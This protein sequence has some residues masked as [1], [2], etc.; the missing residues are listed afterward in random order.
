SAA[1]PFASAAHPLALATRPKD[2]EPAGPGNV[3]R[4]LVGA[5]GFVR[6]SA[7]ELA[8]AFGVSAANVT[9]A[10][11]SGALSISDGE[12]AVAY[13][14]DGDGIVFFSGAPD[15]VLSDVRHFFVRL[16]GGAASPGSLDATPGLSA[17][18]DTYSREIHLEQEEFAGTVV[19][20]DARSDFWFWHVISSASP[21]MTAFELDAPAVDAVRV[22][23][24]MHAIPDYDAT[25]SLW[26]DGVMVG[27][28]L[29]E[30]G[31]TRLGFDVAA[32][33]LGTGEH[34]LEV[35]AGSG[36]AYVD[37]IDLRVPTQFT[38]D[39]ALFSVVAD[40]VLTLPEADG[41]RV[42]DVT[43][44]RAPQVLTGLVME[45]GEVRFQ[46]LEAH[47]YL[48]DRG[49]VS[50][51]ERVEGT[52]PRDITGDLAADYVV[53][54]HRSLLG[55]L[56]PL[57]QAR[58]TDGFATL[59]VDVQD[60]YDE[61]AA[62]VPDPD[63]LRMFL[64]DARDSWS[65]APR[66]VLIAGHGTFDFR[67]C[68][69]HGRQPRGGPHDPHHRRSLR[70]RRHAGVGLRVVGP[71]A[72][73]RPPPGAHRRRAERD[74]WPH[75]G[76]R[77]PR[78]QRRPGRGGLPEPRR[79]LRSQRRTGHRPGPLRLLGGSGCANR[80]GDRSAHRALGSP[81]RVP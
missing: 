79:R 13:E 57:L 77:E 7:T 44:P 68:P 15:H 9:S 26:L 24:A 50:A 36:F 37:E 32:S 12:S 62:G 52:S 74:G 78:P 4:V 8:A 58:A 71:T 67:R 28:Q 72:A 47:R 11:A 76:L 39:S 23:V 31:R 43:D 61:Y 41:V 70:E 14:V 53:I 65:V 56:E 45:A 21:L 29:L 49:D 55:A 30:A 34:S 38:A 22:E 66:Y 33:L 69:G 54:A 59:A 10:I 5:E 6:V 46:A 2:N 81:G 16:T 40:S 80:C 18:T 48:V 19:V 42:F 3:A 63:A 51:P 27:D 17:E 25:V 60:V 75:P 20:E 64:R 1:A 73:H 35:R